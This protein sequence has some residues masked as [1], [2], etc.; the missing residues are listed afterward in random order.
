MKMKSKVK[1]SGPEEWAA[2][3]ETT[4]RKW[5]IEEPLLESRHCTSL[6]LAPSPPP[7]P[8]VVELAWASREWQSRIRDGLWINEQKKKKRRTHRER[9]RELLGGGL[10]QVRTHT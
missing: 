10:V 8:L 1:L 2:D 9:G 6:T 4:E 7:S 3:L 5:R